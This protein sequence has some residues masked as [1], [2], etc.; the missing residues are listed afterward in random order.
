[1]EG[2]AAV[3]LLEEEQPADTKSRIAIIT[4]D[5]YFIYSSEG[6]ILSGISITRF[7]H[8]PIHSSARHPL[9]DSL[10]V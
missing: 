4:I 7:N 1:M 10:I 5:K 3:T 8:S 6:W 2:R 9:C